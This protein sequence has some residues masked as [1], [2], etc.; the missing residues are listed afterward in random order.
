MTTTL[1]VTDPHDIV[2]FVQYQLG[3]VPSESLVLV[4]LR[5]PRRR[6]GLVM[7][8]DLPPAEHRHALAEQLVTYLGRDGAGATLALIYADEPWVRLESPPQRQLLDV[9]AGVLKDAGMPVRE[10][11]H[12]TPELFRSY[13][14]DDVGC[15][16]LP[17]SPVASANASLVAPEMVLRGR[18]V[19]AS[20]EELLAG[21]LPVAS[22]SP[23][24]VAQVMDEADRW[25]ATG[26]GHRWR[27][28]SLRSW[29]AAVH[30]ARYA[31]P[32]D[33]GSD[34]GFCLD[35]T[36]AG[37]LLAALKDVRVRD[38]ALLCLVPGSARAPDEVVAGHT[39]SRV[40]SL[41]DS[42]PDQELAAAARC[43]LGQLAALAR[44]SGWV[45][46]PLVLLGWIAWST[47]DGLQA[48][49]MVERALAVDP[50]HMLAQLLDQM[51]THGVPA[52]WAVADRDADLAGVPRRLP[53]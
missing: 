32:A 7:R 41:L 36:E 28:T 51:V 37:R 3:F 35:P 33:G 49:A 53:A 11:L 15:C 14:C 23:A 42:E 10:A 18:S 24:L 12:V 47:G 2:A 16:P 9:V 34:P 19:A 22:P 27:R 21:H 48:G 5:G 50:Q 38:A 31:R 1:R 30:A 46:S 45:V 44:E 39:P 20:R 6:V 17:G 43:V 26:S 40:G 29:R 25:S 52:A 8:V 4:S 13:W